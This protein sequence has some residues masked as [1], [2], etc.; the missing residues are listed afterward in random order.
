L[1]ATLSSFDACNDFSTLPRDGDD[2][3]GEEVGL[4]P[5]MKDEGL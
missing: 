1:I 3:L 5:T 4:G 2:G